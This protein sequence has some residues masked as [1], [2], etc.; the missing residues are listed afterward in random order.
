MLPASRNDKH[1]GEIISYEDL[2]QE[3]QLGGYHGISTKRWRGLKE[4][5]TGGRVREEET[6]DRN[7]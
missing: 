6:D 1:K 3:D 5:S 2:G 4:H 7:V